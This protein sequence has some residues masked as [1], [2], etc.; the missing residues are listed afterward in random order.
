MAAERTR[1][2]AGSEAGQAPRA[3]AAKA[4][5]GVRSTLA[6]A[7]PA[8]PAVVGHHPAPDGAPTVLLY[9]HHDV[10]PPG[11]PDLWR[12]PAFEPTE[13]DG[14]LYGRGAADDKAGI[15]VHQ[16]GLGAQGRQ[17]TGQLMDLA[18]HSA[19]QAASNAF[20]QTVDDLT[21]GADRKR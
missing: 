20:N 13:R 15:V 12:T 5:A 8:A 10:Q 11:D 4:D 2:L 19:A 9:A 18:D 6:P 1:S 17:T 14:R 16:R 3:E 21:V 7:A